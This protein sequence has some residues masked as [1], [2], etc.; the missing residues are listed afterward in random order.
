VVVLRELGAEAEER[1][2]RGMGHT[3][4]AD[5]MAAAAALLAR[6]AGP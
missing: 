6:L 2:Y 3:V 4:N 1:I 5:E